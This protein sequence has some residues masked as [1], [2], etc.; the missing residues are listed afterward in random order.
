M[1][2]ILVYSAD[3]DEKLTDTFMS[4]EGIEGKG[5]PD[6]FRAMFGYV[7]KNS[8]LK[9]TTERRITMKKLL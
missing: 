2:I 4:S 9:S 1:G 7:L 6:V 5:T 3:G 8:I